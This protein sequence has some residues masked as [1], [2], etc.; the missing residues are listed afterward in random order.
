MLKK[1]SEE[2][3]CICML[4]SVGGFLGDC[5]ATLVC[6]VERLMGGYACY[7]ASVCG[8]DNYHWRGLHGC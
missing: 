8:G 7:E 4:P 5:T 1:T 3:G 6:A 2:C